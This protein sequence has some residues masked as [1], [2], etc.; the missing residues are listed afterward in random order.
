MVSQQRA[1]V[2]MQ[3]CSMLPCIANAF[4][5]QYH[6]TACTALPLNVHSVNRRHPRMRNL[7][8]GALAI[9]AVSAGVVVARKGVAGFK[10]ARR[11]WVQKSAQRKAAKAAAAAAKLADKQKKAAER[12]MRE[13]KA[14]EATARYETQ[15]APLLAL[16]EKRRLNLASLR[17]ELVH[18]QAQYSDALQTILLN[19]A[20]RAATSAGLNYHVKQLKLQV[21]EVQKQIDWLQADVDRDMRA[22]TLAE[23]FVGGYDAVTRSDEI[24]E[25]RIGIRLTTAARK[26]VDKYDID[27]TE[28]DERIQEYQ[29]LA[30]NNAVV[31]FGQKV[32]V[33]IY[34][35]LVPFEFTG[36]CREADECNQLILEQLGENNKQFKLDH[37]AS[38]MHLT[39]IMH[40]HPEYIG[41]KDAC[42]GGVSCH[43]IR[44]RRF[45][46]GLVDIQC[47]MPIN[48]EISVFPHEI[49]HQFNLNHDKQ[50]LEAEYDGHIAH[51]EGE[52]NLGIRFCGD[53][54]SRDDDSKDVQTI[55]AYECPRRRTKPI[56]Y[57][58][59]IHDFVD[60]VRIGK[61]PTEDDPFGANNCAMISKMLPIIASYAKPNPYL[62]ARREQRSDETTAAA[63]AAAAVEQLQQ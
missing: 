61:L 63:A 26:Y 10:K 15:A 40:H 16:A 51:F 23:H 32:K 7:K 9:I 52:T 5:T 29:E 18:L 20:R 48:D 59:C 45:P 44:C 24:T 8:Q 53:D 43:G 35:S 49:G 62:E 56:P 30:F 13:Q 38:G 25:I 27:M 28:M 50:T 31:H 11:W 17:S 14:A 57:Y 34:H 1:L 41:M 42:G 22:R 21:Q 6:N 12:A 36:R 60:G 47:M 2:I 55:M 39:V 46:Y 33:T 54:E 37:K 3:A 19:D 4:L 58:S